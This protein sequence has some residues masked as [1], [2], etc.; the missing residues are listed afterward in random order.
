M[1]MCF[2]VIFPFRIGVMVFNEPFLLTGNFNP[3]TSFFFYFSDLL[4]FGACLF[5]GISRIKVNKSNPLNFGDF[6]ITILLLGFVVASSFP[7]LFVS[8]ELGTFFQAFRLLEMFMLY[9]LFSAGILNIREISFFLLF[10]FLIQL[11]ILSSQYASQESIGLRFLGESHISPLIEG[12]AKVD[13]KGIK[14]L[15]PYGT[16]PHPNV[17][18]AFLTLI[19]G[20]VYHLFHK[21]NLL[22]FISLMLISGALFLTFSRSAILALVTGVMIF[23]GLS[24]TKIPW[25]ILTVWISS[26]VLLIVVF[27]LENL[28]LSRLFN[29]LGDG[30]VNERIGYVQMSLRMFSEN[31]FGV[32]LGQFTNMMQSYS[33]EKIMPWLLQ[34]VHNVFLLLLTEGGILSLTFF[35][36]LL[37]YLFYKLIKATEVTRGSERD[38]VNILIAQ[39]SALVVLSLLDHYFISLPQ[40][41][42]LLFIYF[43]VASLYLRQISGKL[44]GSTQKI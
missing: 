10:A 41:Q 34:P 35:L 15:R 37:G 9:L 12:V 36:G 43:S 5:W 38:F 31:P 7:F 8:S 39:L 44:S 42:V 24:E 25:R 21:R 2:L 11:L 18:A 29:F 1:L 16:F 23:F 30:A 3:Y 32:G 4:I 14:I 26:F 40:G 22:L 17:L 6:G 28:V 33:A 20:W 13:F 19:F 27:N